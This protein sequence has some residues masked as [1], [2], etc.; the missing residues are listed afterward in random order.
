[1]S[2]LVDW[3]EDYSVGVVSLDDQHKQI[4][5]QINRLHQSLLTNTV[6]ETVERCLA[7]LTVILQAHLAEEETLMK[8]IDYPATD[9]HVEQHNAFR[10]SIAKYLLQLK[11]NQP[12]S[13]FSLMAFLRKKLVTHILV[14]DRDLGTFLVRQSGPRVSGAISE[15]VSSAPT[16]ELG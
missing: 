6:A 8:K 10:Q 15:E 12:V 16:T 9:R 13:V 5:D 1:M 2:S 11:R 7:D 14:D 3:S 4:I